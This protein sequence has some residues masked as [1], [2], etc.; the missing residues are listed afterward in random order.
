MRIHYILK[1]YTHAVVGQLLILALSFVNRTIFI[2]YLSIDYLGVSG[3]FTNILSLFSLADLGIGSVI[4]IY[5]YKPLASNDANQLKSLAHLYS[6]IYN[7]I[8]LVIFVLGLT[9]LPFLS[10]LIKEPPEVDHLKI[11][12][13]L[14][15][16]NSSISYFFSYKRAIITADQKEYICTRNNN[17]FSII[18]YAFQILLLILTKNYL[19]YLS[20]AVCSTLMSNINISRKANKLYPF[21]L[22]KNPPKLKREELRKIFK[23]VGAMISHRIGSVFIN[24]TD[25]ILISKFIGITLVGLYSNYYMILAIINGFVILIFNSA[26]ASIGNIN[27][28]EDD[29]KFYE[30]FK[31]LMFV[32]FWVIGFSAICYFILI[33][34]FLKLWLGESF[35]LK[36]SLTLVL[37]INFYLLG[38]SR[39]T[40]NYIGVTKLFWNTRFKPWVEA[41]IKIGISIILINK[42]GIIGVFIGTSISF[43]LMSFWIDPYVLFKYRFK[44]PLRNYYALYLKPTFVVLLSG[45][46]TY[47]LSTYTDSLI[48]KLVLCFLIPNGLFYVI[49][50]KSMEFNYV[51][52]VARA[53]LNDQGFMKKWF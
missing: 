40:Q 28:T 3:L 2:K 17:F 48:L 47:Y 44:I 1:N 46:I 10:H 9:L 38:I 39:V 8:G 21:L 5:L 14:F 29:Q 50:Q 37:T 51:L 36:H 22:E 33:N 4:I 19:I 49:F 12:Y 27:E 31:V 41:M 23:N 7:I 30:I 53:I 43:V 6:R 42:M 16:V 13:L 11:I 25:N 35:L 20:L 52:N 34:P 45:L 18:Q 15:V 32:G 26:S 24:S